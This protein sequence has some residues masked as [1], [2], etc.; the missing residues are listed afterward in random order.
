[1]SQSSPVD[2][3][4][5]HACTNCPAAQSG[6]CQWFDASLRDRILAAS[7]HRSFQR[8]ESIIPGGQSPSR[9]GVI[10]SGLVKISTIDEQGND[11]VLQILHQGEVVGDPFGTSSPFSYDAAT[12]VTICISQ[13][14]PIKEALD[15]HPDAYAAYLRI[16][17]RQQQELHFAQLSMRGRN[18]L[19]RIASW[20]CTQAPEAGTDRVLSVK[21]LLSRRDLASLLEMTVETLSRNLHQLEDRGIIRIVTPERMEILDKVRLRVLA[22]DQ[23]A[24]LKTTLL[25]QGW[26]W[27]GRA[28]TLPRFSP[29]MGKTGEAGLRPQ[30]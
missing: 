22:R 19:Q 16:A 13:R 14:G 9:V 21:I 26:E 5:T 10:L 11:H 8:G 25:R 2:A 28:I 6:L 3:T 1:M 29:F 23:D 30:A 17:I 4:T 20:I 24:R 12:D 18:S 15:R 7:A 27:G